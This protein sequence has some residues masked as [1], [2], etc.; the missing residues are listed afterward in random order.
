VYNG[1]P[2]TIKYLAELMRVPNSLITF[3]FNPDNYADVVVVLGTDWASSN[4]LP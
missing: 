1:K 4:P 2:Y 3:N